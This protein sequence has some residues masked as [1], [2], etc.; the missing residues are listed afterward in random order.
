MEPSPLAI[1][2]RAE[3]AARGR[4][5]TATA[6]AERI[7]AAAAERA[8]VIEAGVP[9]RIASALADLRR[10]HD[11]RAAAEVEAIERDLAA[12]EAEADRPDDLG[13]FDAAVRLVVAAV[14]GEDTDSRRTESAARVTA[15]TA[16]GGG[17]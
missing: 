9:D 13:A 14:L 7:V 6:E 10:V 11:M 15:A 3:L 16:T 1:L 8:T 2:E 12:L 5:L 17:R 4:R